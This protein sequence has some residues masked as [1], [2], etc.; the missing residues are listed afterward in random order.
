MR[1]GNVAVDLLLVGFAQ[2]DGGVIQIIL[3]V[4]EDEGSVGVAQGAADF[5]GN[6]GY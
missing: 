2:V 4:F 5:A 6:S 3:C 1:F